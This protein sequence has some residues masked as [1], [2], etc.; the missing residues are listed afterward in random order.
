MPTDVEFHDF[1]MDQI[2]NAGEVRSRKMFG[3][4]GVYCDGKFFGMIND[5]KF[6]IKPTEAGRQF[7]VD[8][9]EAPGYPGAKPS[10]LIEEKLEDSEWLCELIKITINELP[11]P[12]P[13]RKRKR[14]SD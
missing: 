2:A 10:L 3:E 4:Y 5:N 6:F 1:V 13:K 14:K 9:V 11:E 12:R 7:I 8:V